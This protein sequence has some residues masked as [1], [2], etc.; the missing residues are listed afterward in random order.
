MELQNYTDLLYNKE[1]K[2]IYEMKI[3]FP[4]KIFLKLGVERIQMLICRRQYICAS[5]R[6]AVSEQKKALKR[7]GYIN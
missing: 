1:V 6:V 3:F 7:I 2:G 5:K 4:R